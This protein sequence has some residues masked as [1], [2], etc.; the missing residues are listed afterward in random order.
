M[1]PPLAGLYGLV[2]FLLEKETTCIE[3]RK[4]YPRILQKATGPELS[5]LTKP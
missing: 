2:D 4:T 5:N 3:L 1:V